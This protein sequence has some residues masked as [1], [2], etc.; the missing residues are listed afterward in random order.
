MTMQQ[1]ASKNPPLRILQMGSTAYR[2]GVTTAITTICS[3]LYQEGHEVMLICDGGNLDVLLSQGI[4]CVVTDFFP[5]IFSVL[6][7]TIAVNK[8]IR[9][10]RPDVIHVHGRA[11]SLLCYLSGHFPDWFTLHNTHFTGQV[12]AMDIGP[13]R[14]MLSPTARRFFV[15]DEKAKTYLCQSMGINPSKI[16]VINNG[17]DCNHYREPT[18]EERQKARAQFKISDNQTFVLFIGRLHPS[19]QPT[20][21]IAAAKSARAF[22]LNDIRFAIVGDGELEKQ[23]RREI[24]VAGVQDICKLYEWMDPLEAYF[25]ADLLVMPSLYE[26]FGLVALEA[27]ATGL[28]VIRSRTGGAEKMI[29]EGKNGFCCGTDITD[30]VDILMPI[31]KNPD[32]LLPMRAYAREFVVTHLSSKAQAKMLL[33]HYRAHINDKK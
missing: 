8:A 31:L 11:P 30:F 24:E 28:P 9:Q 32:Q 2:G 10:F 22:G 13:L 15:L 25:A 20:A 33:Q 14:R 26:G 19:K 18:L 3:T 21:L 27:L 7:G 5:K 16:E 23:V 17:V 4:Q 12:G 1:E 6:R 29:V